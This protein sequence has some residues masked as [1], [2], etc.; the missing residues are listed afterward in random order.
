MARAGVALGTII[1]IG[2]SPIL[3]GMLE[4]VLWQRRPTRRWVL[5]TALGIAGCSLLLAPQ[6]GIVID[7]GGVLLAIAAGGAYAIYVIA[8]KQLLTKQPAAAVQAALMSM[9]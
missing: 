1:G 9:A 5:A 3:A 8:S 2:S 4:T 6:D 7:V